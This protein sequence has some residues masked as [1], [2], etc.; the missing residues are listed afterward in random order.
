[1]I[2]LILVGCDYIQW[3]TDGRCGPNYDDAVCNGQADG[4]GGPIW[5][6]CSKW[7]WC[8][9]TP[10]HQESGQPRYDYPKGYDHCNLQ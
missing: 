6:Y 3:T 7:D 8:G 9:E 5:K 4:E 2:I 10:D 1:M